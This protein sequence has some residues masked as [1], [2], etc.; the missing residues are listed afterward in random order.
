[1]TIRTR[2]TELAGIEHPMVQGQRMWV[3]RAELA[4]VSNAGGSASCPR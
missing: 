4:A 2:F 1:M 3:G